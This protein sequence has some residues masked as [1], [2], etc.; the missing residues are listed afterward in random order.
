MM[1][2][3]QRPSNKTVFYVHAIVQ[4][5]L[6]VLVFVFPH[7]CG[8]FFLEGSTSNGIESETG[9]LIIRLYGLLSCANAWILTV[10]SHRA[11]TLTKN[12]L[13]YGYAFCYVVS[14]LEI[15][16]RHVRGDRSVHLGFFGII[17][18]LFYASFATV[19]C[20]I[21]FT[22]EDEEEVEE[23]S[24]PVFT[25]YDGGLKL[26]GL[27]LITAIGFGL[28]G[29]TGLLIPKIYVLIF[30]T[31]NLGV[32]LENGAA[33]CVVRLY[34]CLI[35]A[36]AWFLFIIARTP[37]QRNRLA[38]VQTLSIYSILATITI[39]QKNQD[40]N[41]TVFGTIACFIWGS[42]H[43]VSGTFFA[44]FWKRIYELQTASD[45]E[46][47]AEAESIRQNGVSENSPLV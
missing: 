3:L 17:F 21:C 6:G 41:G 46:S 47:L 39:I 1:S 9:H 34:S 22:S 43:F 32:G 35:C 7:S 2:R 10:T 38:F 27:F 23:S 29:V 20:W 25:R 42:G 12:C 44:Y 30:N 11:T 8:V 4:A 24:N 40:A 19:Y 33:K 28:L 31:G 14:F 18:A 26:D 36:T 37:G 5:L 13:I 16:N 15:C 45:S